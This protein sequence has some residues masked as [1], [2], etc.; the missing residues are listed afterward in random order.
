MQLEEAVVKVLDTLKE[1]GHKENTIVTYRSIYNQII[2]FRKQSGS[3]C[4]P[5]AV[6]EA[7]VAAKR[8]QMEHG[9]FHKKDIW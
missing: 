1:W 7:Y 9:Q 8:R 6:L 3:N 4:S 5:E 2:A